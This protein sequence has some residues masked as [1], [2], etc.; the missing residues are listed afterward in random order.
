[1][2]HSVIVTSDGQRYDGSFLDNTTTYIPLGGIVRPEATEAHVETTIRDAG[3][4]AKLYTY[5]RLNTATVNSTITLRK[6][7]SDTA[8]TVTYT[9]DQTGSKQDTSNSVAVADTD[10]VAWKVVVP[11]EAGTNTMTVTIVGAEF[12][13]DTAENCITFC[14]S[15]YSTSFSTAS[16]TRFIAP[17]GYSSYVT[18]EADT[19]LGILGSYTATNLYAY[20]SANARTSDTVIRTR[21]N[22]VNGNQVITYSSGQTG[23]KE[24][25]SNSDALVSGDE[26]N[27]SLTTGAG[28][29]TITLS[30]FTSRLL[31]TSGSFVMGAQASPWASQ[32]NNN[33]KFA[34]VMGFLGFNVT[35]VQDQFLPQTSFTAQNFNTKCA[36]N[37]FT[38]GSTTLGVRINGASSSISV[39]YS[40]GQTG[41]KSDTVNT[42]S[43]SGGSHTIGYYVT[44]Q[45]Q[46]SRFIHLTSMSVEGNSAA[47]TADFIPRIIFMG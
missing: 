8:L 27:Y 20:A 35:E 3:T 46:G 42:A 2:A 36:S 44:T 17:Y 11:D 32:N 26:Y 25:T 41:D 30:L 24:D 34:P 39:S 1:M 22:R 15:S 7:A 12:T 9:A 47:P 5:V 23:A 19:E 37:S 31:N 4:I 28:A 18:A 40:A 13:P 16:V 21:V 14:T 33:T 38:T 10:K 45:S 6:N 43:V 29:E